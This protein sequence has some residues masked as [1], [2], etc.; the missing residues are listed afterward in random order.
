MKTVIIKRTGLLSNLL[1]SKERISGKTGTTNDYTD[2][3]FMWKSRGNEGIKN[4][5]YTNN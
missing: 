2:A 3:W 4:R 5:N 1:N